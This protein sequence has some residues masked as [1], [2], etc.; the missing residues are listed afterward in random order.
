[1]D[2]YFKNL[3]TQLSQPPNLKKIRHVPKKEYEVFCK[4]YIF[5][6]IRGDDFGVAFCK[7]FMVFDTALLMNRGFEES[8]Q[9]IEDV[10]YIV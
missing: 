2:T 5:D 6:S 9:Y 1:M 8:K 3:V 4:E 7:R 10:G